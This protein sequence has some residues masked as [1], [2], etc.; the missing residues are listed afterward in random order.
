M[1]SEVSREL[2][3]GYAMLLDAYW[4]NAKPVIHVSWHQFDDNFS[5]GRALQRVKV[6]KYANKMDAVVKEILQLP[7]YIGNEKQ[8]NDYIRLEEV[9]VEN[10]ARIC[11]MDADMGISLKKIF[12]EHSRSIP[13][14]IRMYWKT[15]W[16]RVG[17]WFDDGVR[18]SS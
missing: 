3:D 18:A 6:L 14:T 5:K 17:F 12:F 8:T 13:A 10:I 7:L 11:R 4:R 9:L 15:Y 2:I 1:V 16:S